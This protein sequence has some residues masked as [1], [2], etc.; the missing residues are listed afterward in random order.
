MLELQFSCLP[1]STCSCFIELPL[2]HLLLSNYVTG[3]RNRSVPTAL[4][5]LIVKLSM[6]LYHLF[7]LCGWIERWLESKTGSRTNEYG[8]HTHTCLVVATRP[9]SK[10]PHYPR[11]S[12]LLRQSLRRAFNY[13]TLSCWHVTLHKYKL[14]A[15]VYFHFVWIV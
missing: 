4:I 14:V 1:A 12:V 3:K 15:F 13:F 8:T 10:P 7:K 2:C 9:R 6:R 11:G 5:V